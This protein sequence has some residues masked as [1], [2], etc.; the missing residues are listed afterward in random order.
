MTTIESSLATSA[1]LPSKL[2]RIFGGRATVLSVDGKCLSMGAEVVIEGKRGFITGFIA[3][4]PTKL[5]RHFF[6]FFLSLIFFSE[7]K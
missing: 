1:V 6:V 4:E 5:V 7:R 2:G 3:L